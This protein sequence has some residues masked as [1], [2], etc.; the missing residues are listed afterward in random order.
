MQLS[1]NPK[2]PNF[3]AVLVAPSG[4]KGIENA[5]SQRHRFGMRRYIE[6]QTEQRKDDKYVDAIITG[7]PDEYGYYWPVL[8]IHDKVTGENLRGDFKVE[9]P[10]GEFGY[11]DC[12]SKD[13]R[14]LPDNVAMLTDVE[15]KPDISHIMMIPVQEDLKIL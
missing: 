12:Y 5:D 11:Y 15:G 1:F 2:T 9:T 7:F 4:Q 3:K 14:L 13:G 8:N 6:E 10:H